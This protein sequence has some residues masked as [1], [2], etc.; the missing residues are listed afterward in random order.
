MMRGVSAVEK[1]AR[2]LKHLGNFIHI[3]FADDFVILSNGTKKATQEVKEK[4]A[5]FLRDELKLE[6]S[7]EKTAITHV[8]DGFDFLGFHI[9]KYKDTKGVRITP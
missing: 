1:K 5:N 3:R 9:R 2:R 7:E 4:V 8:F 6:L